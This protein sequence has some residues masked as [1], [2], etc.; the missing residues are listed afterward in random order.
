[1]INKFFE[2]EKLNELLRVGPS[3]GRAMWVQEV[4]I[5]NLVF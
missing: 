5:D 3:Q 2:G 4:S 1:M